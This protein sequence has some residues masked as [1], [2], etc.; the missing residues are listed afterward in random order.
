L[1][2]IAVPSRLIVRAAV[3]RGVDAQITTQLDAGVGAR[4]VEESGTIQGANL[5][6]LDR[7]G[8]DGKIGCLRSTHG[9]QT[10]R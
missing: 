6:V 3:E 4:D 8:L 10:R 2:Q 9:E 1:T 5:H 7:L